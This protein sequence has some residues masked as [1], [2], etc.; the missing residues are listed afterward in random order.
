MPPRPVTGAFGHKQRNM[1][2]VGTNSDDLR[3]KA[4]GRYQSQVAFYEK[5]KRDARVRYY[6]LQAVVIISSAITPL[7]IVASVDRWIQVAAPTVASISAGLLAAGQFKES[8]LRRA[9]AVEALKS[10]FALFDTRSGKN[11]SAQV[12]DDKA[13]ETFV[14]RTERICADERGE[15]RRTRIEASHR[16]AAEPQR[17]PDRGGGK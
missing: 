6:L 11:Y 5:T 14:L 7:L 16:Q 2:C 9:R 12:P 17:A 4:L 10:E 3:A 8:W 15:W 13:L 1:T